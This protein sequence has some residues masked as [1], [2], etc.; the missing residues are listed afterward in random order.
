MKLTITKRKNIT[1]D[2]KKATFI[3]IVILMIF[4][5]VASNEI[6]HHKVAITAQPSNGCLSTDSLPCT[7]I[8]KK[9]TSE[10]FVPDPKLNAQQRFLSAI[11]RKLLTVPQPGTYEYILLRAYGAVFVNQNVE[12]KLPQKNIFANEQETQ[13]F[14]GTLIMAHVNGTR[15]CYLQKSAADALNKARIQQQIPLKSGYGSGDCTRTFNTN[16]R[17]WHKYANNQILAKVQQGKETK[18][19]GLVAPPGTS[20]HLWGL[21][22]DLRVSSKEQRKALNQN[23]WFQTVQNDVPH[24]TYVGLTEDNLPLFGFKKQV[25]QGITYWIT[26]L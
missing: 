2:I 11:A 16:L 13:E 14:Q 25:V 12:I 9:T 6:T 1:R 26:P 8:F 7:D 22:I 23:G 19:L 5:I 18:V 10:P 20:Q 3:S 15:D 24:W 21:A 17:F 4:V